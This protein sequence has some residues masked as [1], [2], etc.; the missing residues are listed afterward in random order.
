M[1]D[2]LPEIVTTIGRYPSQGLRRYVEHGKVIPD[3]LLPGRLLMT[4][5]CSSRESLV[6]TDFKNVAPWWVTVV[7]S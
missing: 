3:F 6:H 7:C 5:S 4:M 1:H 2:K